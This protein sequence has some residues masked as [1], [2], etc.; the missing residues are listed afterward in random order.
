MKNLFLESYQSGRAV[1]LFVFTIMIVSVIIDLVLLGFLIAKRKIYK[2]SQKLFRW[3]W[4]TLTLSYLIFL[5][6]GIIGVY[7]N[8]PPIHFIFIFFIPIVAAIIILIFAF[9]NKSKEKKLN[10]QTPGTKTVTLQNLQQNQ[11]FK[12]TTNCAYCGLRVE[13]NEKKCPYCGAH[14]K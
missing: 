9:V 7:G 4:I 3:F 10:N 14:I 1:V 6:L 8:E 5:F 13:K 11:N 12:S 2:K